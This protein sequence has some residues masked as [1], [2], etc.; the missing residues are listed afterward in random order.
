MQ[1]KTKILT[2]LSVAQS[3][4][5][6]GEYNYSAVMPIVTEEWNL[7]GK[8][9]GAV[10]AIFWGGY[11]LSVI[12]TGWLSDRIGGRKIFVLSSLQAGICGLGF[13]SLADSYE[14]ALFLR[15]LTGV[16]QG[17][18]YVPGMKI[19]SGWFPARERGK[20]LGIYTASLVASIAGAYLVTS[21]LSAVYSWRLAFALTSA[22]AF[23]GAFIAYLFVR[24]APPG[25]DDAVIEAEIRPFGDLKGLF[26]HVLR[27]RPWALVTGGYMG[28]NWE[29]FV[30]YGWIGPYLTACGIALGMET[31]EALKLAGMV[32]A[33]CIIVG[34]FS[35][36]LGGALSDRFGRIRVVLYSLLVSIICSLSYGFLIGQ[37]LL[38]LG[39]VGIVYGLS[40]IADSAIYK[41]SLTELV[42]K[43]YIGGALGLQAFFGFGASIAA[44]WVFGYV[45]DL[46][47]WSWAWISAALGAMLGPICIVALKHHPDSIRIK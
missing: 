4:S 7:S 19:L 34:A 9:N 5:M 29:L 40:I 26:V 23:P 22:T 21:S 6:L 32:S 17:G 25:A 38:V 10:I 41:V 13:A 31:Q 43:E 33:I 39:T 44:P 46:Y 35:T 2:L 8:M 12:F 42:P 11:A 30:M 45:L 27:Y 36:I 28:H 18:L 14:S 24:D 16:G 47:G 1:E 3:L 37:P 20:V 15:F